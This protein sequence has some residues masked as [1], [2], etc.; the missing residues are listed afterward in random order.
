MWYGGYPLSWDE[1]L[2]EDGKQECTSDYQHRY[3]EIANFNMTSWECERCGTQINFD[4]IKKH[5]TI[6]SRCS[7]FKLPYEE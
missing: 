7:M 1:S 2:L 4:Q 3:K 6:T 5:Q